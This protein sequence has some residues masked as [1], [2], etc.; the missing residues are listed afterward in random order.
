MNPRLL[1]RSRR[2]RREADDFYAA[3]LGVD[4]GRRRSHAWATEGLP[5]VGPAESILTEDAWASNEAA[6]ATEVEVA[7]ETEAEFESASESEP[8]IAGALL[9]ADEAAWADAW[10][11]PSESDTGAEAE[12]ATADAPML[13]A[14]PGSG[15]DAELARTSWEQEDEADEDDAV[16][17]H[18]RGAGSRDAEW[19]DWDAPEL[20]DA[21]YDG[22]A[23]V[24]PPVVHPH[25]CVELTA[26]A[27]IDV[28]LEDF[29][30]EVTPASAT[31]PP[32]MSMPAPT[33]FRT[34]A[35][36]RTRLPL[37]EEPAGAPLHVFEFT[38]GTALL[39]TGHLRIDP[40][41]ASRFEVRLRGLLC[42]PSDPAR[43]DRLPP[44]RA[45]FP[46]AL[47]VHGNHTAIDFAFSDAGRPRR[48][49][50]I[51]T[52]SG[53]V[54]E[55]V[56]QGRASVRHEVP[57]YRGY[58]DLQEHLA[59]QGIVSI[60]LDT[61]VANELGSLIRLRADL[62]LAMLDHL[63]T[64][65]GTA[66]SPLYGRLDLQRVALVGHS[67]GGDAVAMAA[68]LDLARPA[69][70]R[71]G[72][73]AVVALAPTDFTG[74]L[75]PTSERLAVTAGQCAS[76]L[77]VYGSHDGDVSGAFDPTQLSPAWDTVGTGFRHYD[78]ATT[79]RAMVFVHG[80]THNRFNAVW[81]DPAAHAPGSAARALALAE[82]D[83]FDD[84]PLVD[85]GKPP[86]TAFP[87]PATHRDARVLD[88]AAHRTLAREYI[89]DW[90]ALWL[91]G[92]W[93][94][95]DRFTG[96]ATNSLGTPV[97]LQWK[98]GRA[99]RTV[100]EFDD[101][102]PARNIGGGS[103][104]LPTFV[105]ERMIELD[106]LEHTPH[107]ERLLQAQAPSGAVRIYRTELAAAA[108]DWRDF[109]ALSV[110]I[111]KQFPSLASPADIAAASFPPRFT[112]TL[113]DGA[114]RASVDQS[115]I[116]P[117]NPRTVRPYH[118][119][120]AGDDLTKVHLQTWQVPLSRFAGVD[121]RSIRAVEIAFDASAAEPIHLDT[122]SIVKL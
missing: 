24:G 68:R 66:A 32:T 47:I 86:S 82:A 59:S 23:E 109:T 49:R 21:V 75:T 44:G 4:R 28:R 108:R 72:L 80:A 118:R 38:R 96:V 50:T 13:A 114:R 74:M 18:D 79:Q 22:P 16:E 106:D 90:L 81:I 57:S 17:A 52:S 55:T 115:V 5:S 8:A 6:G 46:V 64:L 78:R 88:A 33:G 104:T 30:T 2:A 31:A 11:S 25:H 39:D 73:R 29:P 85:P 83:N 102:N 99:L 70:T 84:A 119:T 27:A 112:L 58:R 120:L 35:A 110:R 89:G 54:T 103:V 60:S 95:A 76:F 111:S 19:D 65:A 107:N 93:S 36:L 20:A 62:V 100:D 34:I 3:L 53:P 9:E 101:S 1:P 42:H 116:A 12:R 48:T 14:D 97:G 121:R 67:R 7:P 41:D 117:L 61:N 26:W 10:E 92:R 63:R 37:E 69:A 113:F 43:P 15:D 122:L 77:C 87:T 71:F 98:L 45:R 91:L 40:T 105:R 56:I 51:P 94:A